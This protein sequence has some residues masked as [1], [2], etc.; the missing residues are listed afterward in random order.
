MSTIL[1]FN[2]LF[3]GNVVVKSV[4][5]LL[6]TN[7]SAFSSNMFPDTLT[8]I[9]LV[10]SSGGYIN[11]YNVPYIDRVIFSAVDIVSNVTW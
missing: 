5:N 7:G 3:V 11:A 9:W 10:V 4:V 6:E 2:L 8:E 1:L